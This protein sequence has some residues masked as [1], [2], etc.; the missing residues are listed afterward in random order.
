MPSFGSVEPP[1]MNNPGQPPQSF[2]FS[3]PSNQTAMNSKPSVNF[4][5]GAP[6]F[7]TPPATNTFTPSSSTPSSSTLFSSTPTF[8]PPTNKPDGPPATTFN[9]GSSP[10]SATAPQQDNLASIVPQSPTLFPSQAQSTP[11]VTV[12]AVDS[13]AEHDNQATDQFSSNSRKRKDVNPPLQ[14]ADSKMRH[15]PSPLSLFSFVPAQGST[16][17]APASSTP[18]GTT[19]QIGGSLFG[20]TLTTTPPTHTLTSTTQTQLPQ[21]TTTTATATSAAQTHAPPT[22]TNTNTDTNLTTSTSTPLSN[23]ILPTT[24]AN[25]TSKLSFG[26]FGKNTESTPKITEL[27]SNSL[28]TPQSNTPVFSFSAPKQKDTTAKNDTS[29]DKEPKNPEEMMK[30]VFKPGPPSEWKVT[31]TT[32]V[33]GLPTFGE[34]SSGERDSLSGNTST[35]APIIRAP[36]TLQPNIKQ[37]ED[38]KRSTRFSELPPEAMEE[39]VDL[40]QFISKSVHISD[41]LDAH[42]LSRNN[43]SIEYIRQQAVELKEKT[44]ILKSCISGKTKELDELSKDIAYQRANTNMVK[45]FLDNP[46]RPDDAFTNCAHWDYFIRLASDLQKRTREY[47]KTVQII[48]QAINNF[49][50]NDVYM[51]ADIKYTMERQNRE[52]MSLAARVVDL[53]EETENLKSKIKTTINGDIEY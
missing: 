9:F 5:F 1:Q 47:G 7:Q 51:P 6:A 29:A 41:M 19:S 10:F 25:K 36:T 50:E 12:T 42:I 31:E 3:L 21:T 48:E 23:S 49:S 34:T 46:S 11:Q 43:G 32:K 38:I 14:R 18:P 40:E 20:K 16:P 8:T 15:G 52:F 53:H 37:R 39:L 35:S 44:E 2:S 28:P 45:L 26:S 17:I 33:A 27:P 30:N 13:N 24:E 4:S 22:F